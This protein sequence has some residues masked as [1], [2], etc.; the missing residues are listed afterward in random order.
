MR[1]WEICWIVSVLW[2]G[3]VTLPAEAFAPR[4]GQ[5][6]V[7][8]E[9][10]QDDLYV[11][12]G[13]V[14]VTAPIDGDLVT[15]G[16]AVDLTGDVS[17]GVLAAEGTVTAGGTI[18]RTLRAAGGTVAVDSHVKS[19]AVL[20]GGTVH[21]GS[22]T[23]IGRDLVVGGG[24][25]NVSGT[26]GRNAFIG[27]GD[28]VIGGAI[29]GDAEIQA[30]RI[31]L[32]RTA[33]IG[34]A[35]RYSA[36]QPIEVQT[37]A[38]I[39]GGATQVP[40]PSRPRR[41]IGAPF[42][43]RLW[44]WR[45]V[46]EAIGLLVLGLATF[47]AAPAGALPVV[48]EV[49]ERFGRSALTGFVLLVT[50]PAAAGLL[51]ITVIGIPLSVVGML[52]YVATLYYALVFVAAWLGRQILQRTRRPGGKAPSIYWAVAVGAVVLAVLFAAPFAGW[53]ARLVAIV[54]GFGALWTT[55]W[56]AVAARPLPGAGS[57]GTTV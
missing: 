38:Q 48:R 45:G 8:S 23:Q 31:V 27:G 53:F 18:G 33:R 42:S 2:I 52:L 39:A 16:G 50:A 1:R 56:G 49:E 30:N 35:L 24:G 7:V 14:T 40:A 57:P 46:A 13:T 44:L 25:V 17:G 20:A 21:M 54:A 4:A 11:A 12:G 37:G 32:L 29:H 3:G 5:T 10:L 47:A 43:S 28:V 41:A 51:A 34:G 15:G 6:V 55:V 19:D 36:D 9:A 22:A 26:V